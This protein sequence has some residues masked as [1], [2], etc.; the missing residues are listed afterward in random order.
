MVN[1]HNPEGH[2][3][4]LVCRLPVK[5]FISPN[6]P[7]DE[8]NEVCAVANGVSHETLNNAET[9]VVA[10]PE[11]GRHQLDQLFSDIDPTGFTSRAPSNPGSPSGFGSQSRRGS[12]DGMPSLDGLASSLPNGLSTSLPNG[13]DD[14][15]THGSASPSMLHSRLRDLQQRGIFVGRSPSNSFSHTPSGGNSPAP[16]AAYD[17]SR[18]I[19]SSLP[20]RMTL[21]DPAASSSPPPTSEPMSRRVSNDSNE[22]VHQGDYDMDSLARV[23]SYG[24]ALRSSGTIT[25]YVQAPPTYVEATSRPPSPTGPREPLLQR[26]GQAHVR[27][28]NETPQTPTGSAYVLLLHQTKCGEDLTA[29]ARTSFLLVCPR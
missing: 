12:Q 20:N 11:Y 8:S 7:V 9:S 16:G 4:Q 17:L 19:P 15:E 27:S 21:A 10:P 29:S 23:P 5:I 25:P 24:F 3:S 28:G 2:V 14:N 26:P 22:D 18:S 1:I 6:L 13:G